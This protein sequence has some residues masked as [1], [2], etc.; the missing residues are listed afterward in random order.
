[1]MTVK[2]KGKSEQKTRWSG[3]KIFRKTAAMIL[4][5]VLALSC[6]TQG[7]GAA[8]TVQ[9]EMDA[10]F[11]YSEARSM[12]KLI[13]NFRTGDDAW[14]L[15][16][17]NRTRVRVKGL[18]A[19]EYDYNLEKVAMQ[20]A[21]EIAVYFSH[22]RP[23]GAAWSSLYPKGYSARGENI[24]YGFGTVK[25]VFKAFAEEKEKYAGQ[26][27]RRVMLNKRF[28]RVGVGAV[29]VG[30]VMYWVQEFGCGGS[31]GSDGKKMKTAKVSVSEKVLKSAAYKVQAAEKNMTVQ[32]GTSEKA[33]AV[34]IISRSGAKMTL[35]DC[36]WKTGSGLVKVKKDKV[37]GVRTGKTRLTAK[38]AG[39]SLSVPVSV[40]TKKPSEKKD[41]PDVVDMTIIE[42]Y[43]PPLGT[44]YL[45]L[46]PDDECFEEEGEGAWED[47]GYTEE[48][49][50]PEE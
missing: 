14:Y 24:A 15:S 18:K 7:A 26:G 31:K 45:V 19:L 37:T 46:E 4:T 47:D 30:S 33:P 8:G 48:Y 22:T 50:E 11:K 5:A 2:A 38:A 44:E 12:L 17:N 25:S 39:V 34:V 23:N 35:K 36:E 32:V 27:H 29:Q 41:K 9:V 16:S 43:Q 3:L 20:R 13:N 6:L 42:E 21:A 28:T 40:V 1:M 10:E 49:I